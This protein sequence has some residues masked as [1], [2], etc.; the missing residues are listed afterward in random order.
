VSPDTIAVGVFTIVGTIAGALVGLFGERFVRRLGYVR[1]VVKEGGW[2]MP[3]GA[4]P[5]GGGDTPRERRLRILFL[6]HKDVPVTVWDMHVKFYSGGKP[7]PAWTRPH[8]Q[9]VAESGVV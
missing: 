1:C 9:L 5:P 4:Y 8:V 2:Y 7:L 6:N 3:E